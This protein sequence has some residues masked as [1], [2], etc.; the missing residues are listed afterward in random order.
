MAT[1]RALGRLLLCVDAAL[2]AVCEDVADE[3]VT[4]ESN[5]W[6]NLVAAK[7]K[8]DAAERRQRSRSRREP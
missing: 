6:R 5:A 3:T 4:M 1:N 8:Y 7:E 2:E